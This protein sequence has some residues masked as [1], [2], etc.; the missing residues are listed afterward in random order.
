MAA[1]PFFTTPINASVT[2]VNAD[3]TATKDLIPTGLTNTVGGLGGRAFSLSF[4]NDDSASIIMVVSL[5]DGTTARVLRE[6]SVAANA[7]A[8][9]VANPPAEL[10]TPANLP[11]MGTMPALLDGWPLNPNC[12]IRVNAKTAVPSTRTVT[13][14]FS[15]GNG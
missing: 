15:G 8:G 14:T 12:R 11:A 1:S 13:A 9:T 2:F 10:F 3:G 4:T 5:F 6:I 7:G